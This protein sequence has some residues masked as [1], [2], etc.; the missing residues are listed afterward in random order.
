MSSASNTPGG[1]PPTLLDVTSLKAGFGARVSG[2]QISAAPSA[3]DVTAVRELWHRHKLLVLPAQQVEEPDLVGF[4][5][6]LGKLEI[7]V[8]AEYLSPQHPELL[9]V[10]NMRREG[11]TIGILADREVGWHYDQIYLPKPAVGSLLCAVTL[12]EAGG[13]T[14]FA[15]MV[16]A[17]A[18]LP[19][20]TRE[21]LAGAEAIQSY[22]A[23][24][25]MYSVPTT[26]E[27]A[28]RTPDLRQPVV[29]THPYTG[30]Q[31]LYLCPGMTTRITG[32]AQHESDALLQELFDWSV[33]E[34]FVYRHRWEK[35]DCV[36]WD[37]AA[38]MHRRDPFSGGERLMKRTTILPDDD[39]ARPFYRAESST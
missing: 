4:S 22:A 12:P 7:H 16:S 17:Y 33:Q 35:G 38:T 5:A 8:R 24:N 1:G 18:A 10:S 19:A 6:A 31:A 27:Q 2:L 13:D 30:E 14:Y 11:R 26:P 37:N 36:L 29:R 32:M 25:A 21:R 15:D 9:Y 23:F 3:V 39:R 34:R 20:R 28:A